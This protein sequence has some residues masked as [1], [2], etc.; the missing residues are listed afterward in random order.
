MD[1]VADAGHATP[2]PLPELTDELIVAALERTRRA[3]CGALEERCYAF[4]F[5]VDGAK[6]R[7]T[8]SGRGTI[9]WVQ[10][11]N[12]RQAWDAWLDRRTGEGRLRVLPDR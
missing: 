11:D 2:A 3:V 7:C 8:P 4:S 6:K 10:R 12:S 5:G 1:H 9:G